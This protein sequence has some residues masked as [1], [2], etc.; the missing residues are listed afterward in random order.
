MNR[1][2]FNAP[3][4]LRTTLEEA[5]LP[6]ALTG[7]PL[8]FREEEPPVPSE[9]IAE[10]EKSALFFS[11]GLEVLL[12][13]LLLRSLLSD[14][15]N[16]LLYVAICG[17]KKGALYSNTYTHTRKQ[18]YTTYEMHACKS[19]AGNSHRVIAIVQR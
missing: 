8:V 11:V 3:V 7:V 9:S 18:L 14:T 17:K 2:I 13:L 16:S 12:L 5:V 6:R 1:Y 4:G 10:M 15:A 19:L